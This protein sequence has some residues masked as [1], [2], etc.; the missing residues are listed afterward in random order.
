VHS[1][2]ETPHDIL[3]ETGKEINKNINHID[4]NQ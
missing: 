2:V 1:V 4:F 3:A